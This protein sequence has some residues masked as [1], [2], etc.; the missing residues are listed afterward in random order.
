MRKRFLLGALLGTMLLMFGLLGCSGGNASDEGTQKNLEGLPIWAN[1]TEVTEQARDAIDLFVSGDYNALAALFGNDAPA[2]S[3]FEKLAR[4]AEEV[5]NFESY[6]DVSF[7]HYEAGSE[8][9]AAIVLQQV[10]CENDD[11]VYSVGIA[12]NGKLVGFRI[13]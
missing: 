1:E 2:A 8:G 3:D 11:L 9:M 5:G 13:S 7:A 12:E 10:H 6:G 4:A